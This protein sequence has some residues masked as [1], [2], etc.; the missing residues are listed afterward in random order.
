VPE[1]DRQRARAADIASRTVEY[2]RFVRIAKILLPSSAAGLFL[3]VVLYSALHNSMSDIQIPIG[4]LPK[5]A[6]ELAM[7]NPTLTY[8]DDANRAFSVNADR[9]TQKDNYDLWHLTSIRGRMTPPEGRG[10]KLT[11]DTG[12]LD[13]AKKLL[14]LA[15]RVLVV[16]DEGYTFEAR[17]AHVDMT[18]NRVTSEEPVRAHGGA[19]TINSDRFEMWDKGS[20]L[21]FEGRVK[22]VSESAPRTAPLNKNEP[23]QGTSGAKP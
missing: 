11:S 22:F 4:D 2:S 9:A 1:L 16:S 21:R 5:I 7:S 15:G 3:I 6:G 17:S 8:T 18:Q 14:D 13:A 19:T 23:A 12:Q 20:K 10:Y